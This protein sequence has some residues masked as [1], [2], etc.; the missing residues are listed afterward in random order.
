MPCL[1][2]QTRYATRSLWRHARM[3]QPAEPVR[4]SRG[5][6]SRRAVQIAGGTRRVVRSRLPCLG[7]LV[8]WHSRWDVGSRRVAG[9]VHEFPSRS[10]ATTAAGSALAPVPITTKTKT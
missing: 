8:L 10:G 6:P 5:R 2:R 3:K 9:T 1:Q 7:A 4:W